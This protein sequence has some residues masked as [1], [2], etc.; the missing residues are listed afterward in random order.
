MTVEL[1]ALELKL[2]EGTPLPGVLCTGN[3]APASCDVAPG[4]AHRLP[5]WVRPRFEPTLRELFSPLG[6][7]ARLVQTDQNVSLTRGIGSLPRRVVLLVHVDACE[8]SRQARVAVF[9]CACARATIVTHEVCIVTCLAMH[10][11]QNA[12]ATH[13]MGGVRTEVAW[14]GRNRAHV[15]GDDASQKELGEQ[16]CSHCLNHVGAPVRVQ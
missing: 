10:R 5:T 14:R 3:T 16:R 7:A 15:V 11:V 6:T 4:V 8:S 9:K 12:V 1:E 13:S 2:Y